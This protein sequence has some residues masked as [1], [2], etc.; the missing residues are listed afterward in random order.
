VSVVLGAVNSPIPTSFDEGRSFDACKTK[1]DWHCEA[2][3]CIAPLTSSS[4][5]YHPDYLHQLL[6]EDVMDEKS[7]HYFI[8]S[9]RIL[10]LYETGDPASVRL[11]LQS[12]SQHLAETTASQRHLLLSMDADLITGLRLND[13]RRFSLSDV[14][15]GQ[16]K[17]QADLEDFFQV[18]IAAHP[19][20]AHHLGVAKQANG[21][22]DLYRS[23]STKLDALQSTLSLREQRLFTRVTQL[24]TVVFGS[25]G[26]AS[27]LV[28]LVRASMAGDTDAVA[29]GTLG[30]VAATGLILVAV[31]RARRLI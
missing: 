7:G 18:S 25:V 17:K 19:V 13:T 28:A 1:F 23:V 15:E 31:I 29:A 3:A 5:A 21:V 6:G 30:L 22:E 8:S 27:F 10:G 14:L 12:W 24:L 16:R 2:A 20:F 9:Q 11:N 26:V 4:E